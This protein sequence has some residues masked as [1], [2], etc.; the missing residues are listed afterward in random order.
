MKTLSPALCLLAIFGYYFGS[1]STLYP[2]PCPC[3]AATLY[4][5]GLNLISKFAFVS[6]YAALRFCRYAQIP[7][8]PLSQHT[9]SCFG[10][11]RRRRRRCCCCFCCCLSEAALV[12]DL[13]TSKSLNLLEGALGVAQ[14]FQFCRCIGEACQFVQI[15]AAGLPGLAQPSASCNRNPLTRPTRS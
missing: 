10:R 8:N 5:H 7:P 13:R 15:V 9:N 4:G 14:H 6:G 2:Y 11:R 1:R 3:P 12:A